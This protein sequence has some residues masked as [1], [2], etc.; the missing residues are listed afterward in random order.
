MYAVTPKTDRTMAKQI[1]LTSEEVKSLI[2]LLGTIVNFLTKL[3]KDKKDG[4]EK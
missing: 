4:K 1:M 2:D 3:L